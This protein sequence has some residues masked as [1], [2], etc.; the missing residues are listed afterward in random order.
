[1]VSR[2]MPFAFQPSESEPQARVDARRWDPKKMCK[3]KKPPG[4]Q[5]NGDP[6]IVTFDGA[7]YDFQG[8]GEFQLVTDPDDDGFAIQSRN[9]PWGEVRGFSVTAALALV[10]GSERVTLTSDDVHGESETVVVRVNGEPV[11]A[12]EAGG[13][14]SERIALGRGELL[15]PTADRWQVSWPDGSK[16]E[17]S[18]HHGLFLSLVPDSDRGEGLVGLLGSL[19]GEVRND[20]VVAGGD[21]TD[22]ASDAAIN[23]D[24]AAAVHDRFDDSWRIT[25]EES[26]FDYA[27]GE[28]TETFTLLDFPQN[29]PAP[30]DDDTDSARQECLTRLPAS[31]SVVDLQNCIFDVLG[32]GDVGFADAY[33]DAAMISAGQEP[34]SP[35][36]EAPTT[37]ALPAGEQGEDGS[38]LTLAG[39]VS[40][41]GGAAPLEGSFDGAANSTV[42]LRTSCPAGVALSVSLVPPGKEGAAGLPALGTLCGDDGLRGAAPDENDLLIPGE[43]SFR[44]PV[45]GRYSIEVSA[46]AGVEGADEVELKIAVFTD[47]EP[48]VTTVNESGASVDLD[49]LASTAVLIVPP[50]SGALTY[51][52]SGANEVCIS[53]VALFDF[54]RPEAPPTHLPVCEIVDPGVGVTNPSTTDQLRLLIWSRLT[55]GSTVK[56]SPR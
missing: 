15:H 24:D 14:G 53:D 47:P 41:F 35:A 21:P 11:S 38:V 40:G 32:T 4:G 30:D 36:G 39:G 2:N 27:E 9:V 55:A 19:D 56:L 51:E 44:L 54:G 1:M 31:A 28:S 52:W 12:A 5:Q 34:E 18:W 48:Q 17:I 33:A 50:G 26:L 10:V 46:L 7:V 49:G 13:G 22:L 20:L 3:K 25:D 29:E 43:T 42:L 16:A 23:P 37:S 6:H 45:D 8:A